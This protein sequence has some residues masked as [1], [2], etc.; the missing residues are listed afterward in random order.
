MLVASIHAQK[1]RDENTYR[2]LWRATV[3]NDR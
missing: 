3:A 2:V 1:N